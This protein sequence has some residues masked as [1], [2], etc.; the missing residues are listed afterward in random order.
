MEKTILNLI[1]DEEYSYIHYN[2]VNF[3]KEN[4]MM[5]KL[6]EI[7]S[8]SIE[9][10]LNNQININDNSPQSLFSM[11]NYYYKNKNYSSATKILATLINYDNSLNNNENNTN[12]VTLDDRITYVNTM[13]NTLDLQIKDA[14]YNQNQELKINEINEAKSLKE[15]MINV[16]GDHEGVISHEGTVIATYKTAKSKTKF[17]EKQFASE[18]PDLYQQYSEVIEGSRIFSKVVVSI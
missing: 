7:N 15:K 3:L 13:L 4:N 14:E 12:R 10:Y 11:F 16:I 18:H 1:F 17:N 9:K 8:T 6:Q 5:N 2:I